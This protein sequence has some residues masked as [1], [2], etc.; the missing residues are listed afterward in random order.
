MLRSPVIKMVAI[1]PGEFF[2][3]SADDDKAALPEEKPRQKV[4]M[5]RPFMLGAFEVT[6]EEYDTVM[7]TNPS[8]FSPKNEPRLKDKDTRTLPV[9]TV[10]WLDAIRF[11][12]MLSL[13]H[14]LE[15]YYEIKGETVTRKGGSGYRLPTEAEWEYAC[16][17]GTSTRWSFGDDENRLGDFAWFAGNS[18]N[19]THAVGTKKPNAWGLYD[20]YGNVAE[21]CWD[22]YKD[23]ALKRI[24]ATDPPGP[25]EG[26]TRVHRGGEWNS[27]LPQARSASRS[28]LGLAYVVEGSPNRIGFRVA[29]DGEE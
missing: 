8:H 28:S 5:T 19:Q 29:H 18:D 9:D 13:R 15:P 6:Q 11:C 24:P 16:R 14:G 26:A 7:G 20:M 27:R 12:N 25:G 21:W 17:A 4:T 1:K 3:G 22:R 2:M 23:D 10:S